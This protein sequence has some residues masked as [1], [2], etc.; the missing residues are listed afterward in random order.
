MNRKGWVWKPPYKLYVLARHLPDFPT[1]HLYS[2]M[3]C[4]SVEPCKTFKAASLMHDHDHL[5]HRCEELIPSRIII[6]AIQATRYQLARE[7]DINLSRRG[8]LSSSVSSKPKPRVEDSDNDPSDQRGWGVIL[9]YWAGLL[10]SLI[11]DWR[12][13]G[14]RWRWGEENAERGKRKEER[15]MES[16]FPAR[17]KPPDGNGMHLFFY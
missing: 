11:G 2:L 10:R 6:T 3:F 5:I 15:R 14:L 9:P 13:I 4:S 8:R 1:R 12:R 17:E 16:N 7:N